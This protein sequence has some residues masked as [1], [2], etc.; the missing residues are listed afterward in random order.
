LT[1]NCFPISGIH[2]VRLGATTGLGTGAILVV[3]GIR[4][5]VLAMTSA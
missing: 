5:A 4:A 2:L 1:D 3:F